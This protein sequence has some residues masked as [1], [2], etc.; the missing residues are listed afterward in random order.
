MTQAK[1]VYSL[2][3][4]INAIVELSTRINVRCEMTKVPLIFCEKDLAIDLSFTPSR[5]SCLL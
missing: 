2:R 5:V 4:K 1:S 3:P